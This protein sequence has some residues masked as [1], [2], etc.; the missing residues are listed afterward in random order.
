MQSYLEDE[1]GVPAPTDALKNADWF[2]AQQGLEKQKA[3]PSTRLK[4]R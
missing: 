4:R 1:S 3:F 2:F